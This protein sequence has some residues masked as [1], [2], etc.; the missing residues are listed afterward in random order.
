MEM[1][2]VDIFTPS[3]KCCRCSHS[4]IKEVSQKKK[5][6][7]GSLLVP[8]CLQ[9]LGQTQKLRSSLRLTDAY[10]KS[11]SKYFCIS[12][13]LSLFYTSPFPLPNLLSFRHMRMLLAPSSI[14]P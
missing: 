12:F 11:M 5:D 7:R 14:D 8:C 4:V 2:L 3:T 1:L 9:C 13:L 6:G 10:P